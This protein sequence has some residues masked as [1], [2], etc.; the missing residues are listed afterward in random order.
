M[1]AVRIYL[2][3]LYDIIHHMP[4]LI[5]NNN[6]HHRHLHHH[7][8]NCEGLLMYLIQVYFFMEEETDI[9]EVWGLLGSVF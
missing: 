1:K 6:H 7:H 5:I 3:D 4:L 9:Q 8:F 2:F